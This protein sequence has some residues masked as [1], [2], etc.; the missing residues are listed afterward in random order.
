MFAAPGAQDGATGAA[1]EQF[2]LPDGCGQL[3][4]A[5]TRL[6]KQIGADR[7]AAFDQRIQEL[8]RKDFHAL[9]Q[10]CTGPA[11][12]L[13]NLAPAM[14]NEGAAF[15]DSLLEGASVADLFIKQKGGP[16]ADPRDALMQAYD[17]AAPEP[18]K[19]SGGK[20][21]CV[22][23]VP[24]DEQG[25]TLRDA[26]GDVLP[27]AKVVTSD[28]SD[29]IVFYREQMD[30]TSADLEQFV[31]AA[32]EAYRQ[33][34]AQDPGVLHCREDIPQWQI[35]MTPGRKPEFARSC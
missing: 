33:R 3:D 25:E 30:L 27:S 10:I 21:L 11:L 32:K 13:K 16:D 22:V 5:V 20:E 31:P 24:S 9:V 23:V 4:E 1:N 29:E 7:I 34:E 28:R 17:E 12:V 14:L 35:P 15:L 26:L 18:A 8:I 6:D 19:R 2:L